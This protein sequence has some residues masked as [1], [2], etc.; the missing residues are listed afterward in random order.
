MV[1]TAERKPIAPH[2]FTTQPTSRVQRLRDGFLDVKASV[3]IERARIE[4]RVMRA[5]EGEPMVTRRAKVMAAVIRE[6]PIAIYPD[7]LI[8]GITSVRP[9]CSNMVPGTVDPVQ[10]RERMMHLGLTVGDLKELEEDL[11]PYWK[12]QGKVGRLA[13]W[14]YGHNIHDMRKVMRLGFLAIKKEA[15]DRLARLDMTGAEDASKVTFLKGVVLVMEAAAEL[16][17]RYAALARDMAGKE[18]NAARKVELLK[19][20]EICDQVPAYPARNFYEA[21]QSYHFAW[22][23][24]IYENIQNQSFALGQM[25]QYLLPYYEKDLRDGRITAEW[26]QELLD[27]YILKLNYLGNKVQNAHASLGV[28]GYKANG[29]DATNDLT[30]MFVESVMH[31]RLADPWFAIHVHSK[32]P[33]ALLIK[34]AELVS[35]GSGSSQFIN[36]DTG[37]SQ[38]LARGGAGQKAVT[39]EDARAASNVGCLELVIPGKD[40]GYFMA[41][42]TSGTNLAQVLELALNNGVSRIDGRKVGIETGDPRTFQ[43]FEEVKEA[44][45]EQLMHV[46][47][48]TQIDH[49]NFEQKLIEL[50][51]TIYQSAL[52]EGCIE[53]GKAREEGGAIYNNQQTQCTGA[54]DVGDSLAAIKKLVFE[55]KKFTM[56]QLCDALDANFVGHQDILKMCQAVP[57]FGNDD[58]YADEQTVWVN[59][60]WASEFSKIKNLRGGYDSPG[61]SSMSGYIGYGKMVGALPSGRRA[62]EPLA[63]AACPSAGKDR[64]GA[65]A[66]V[67]SMGKIDHVE[68]LSGL[69]FTTRIDPSV[70]ENADGLKRTADLIRTFVDQKIFHMQ[71]NV[72]SSETLR[73]AQKEPEKYRDLMVK[74]AGYN[75][76]FTRID[77]ELQDSIIARTEHGL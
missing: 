19:L 38:M 66:A 31:T 72:V 58:D 15:E 21:L 60:V 75:A 23:M 32:S 41:P 27:C 45:Y 28:G 73:D 16:G 36:S 51:P 12:E 2:F 6:M 22:L 7:E 52:I 56:A 50:C 24:L 4:A 61:G 42:G 71:F 47:K 29:N 67:K 77:K 62:R 64:N 46:Q 9:C 3:S 10:N 69:A 13:A 44:Y 33:D 59:H 40:S 1:Q 57:K 55:D 49:N 39:L 17:L 76:Y 37:I 68:V 8:V 20:A 25:D 26:A 54:A 14:H 18:K 53:S 5:T 70:F 63:P 48:L 43:T 11:I 65:T 30:M 34:A 74:V 35:L